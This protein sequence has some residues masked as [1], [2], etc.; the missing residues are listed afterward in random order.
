MKRKILAISLGA[1]VAVG[2]LFA[3]THGASL[4]TADARTLDR[5]VPNAAAQI[6]P[7][8]TPTPEP[9]TYRVDLYFAD[10]MTIPQG[11]IFRSAHNA[12]VR[13]Q[14][15]TALREYLALQQ[16][17]D[18]PSA[19]VENRLGVIYH[20]IGN[21][22]FAAHQFGKAIAANDNY[23]PPWNRAKANHDFRRCSE[24]IEDAEWLLEHD[25]RKIWQVATTLLD[26]GPQATTHMA[27]HFIITSCHEPDVAIEWIEDEDSN[28]PDGKKR[29]PLQVSTCHSNYHRWALN[30]SAIKMNL[31]KGGTLA[32]PQHPCAN[33][34]ST[35]E[36]RET[37]KKH[38]EKGLQLVNTAKL[39]QCP[40][41]GTSR[42]PID[43]C[44]FL[45][46]YFH[47]AVAA[48]SILQV[49]NQGDKR[50]KPE[51]CEYPV[52]RPFRAK[53]LFP[54][55]DL[56]EGDARLAIELLTGWKMPKRHS[57]PESEYRE[58]R[59]CT[60]RGGIASWQTPAR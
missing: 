42:L 33:Q 22:A 21:Q 47:E 49:S 11:D 39:R 60:E 8:G 24:A 52:G 20:T 57:A 37:F 2:A 23:I 36:R 58:Y 17:L 10:E 35:E 30:K 50:P 46:R 18:Q 29:E 25:D 53:S 6:A 54:N 15:G 41:D 19:L 44:P 51:I 48:G 7:P 27:A 55:E 4:K 56:T 28:K 16:E 34:W 38:A 13:G 3:V 31:K 9:E 1:T 59:E 32:R 5:P 40:K 43:A 12:H 14:V 45:R 26:I